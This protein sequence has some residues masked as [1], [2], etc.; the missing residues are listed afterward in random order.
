MRELAQ[1]KTSDKPLVKLIC[2]LVDAFHFTLTLPPP[3]ATSQTGQPP[4]PPLAIPNAAAAGVAAEAGDGMQEEVAAEEAEE[5]EEEEGAKVVDGEEVD[6]AEVY[7]QVPLRLRITKAPPPL[8]RTV[9][10]LA[11]FL[12][13]LARYLYCG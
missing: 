12:L 4:A 11:A 1:G 8:E 7:R 9:Q 5:E 13:I 3:D 2:A 6:G 10:M